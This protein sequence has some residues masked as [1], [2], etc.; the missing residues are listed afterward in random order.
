VKIREATKLISKVIVQVCTPTSNEGVSFHVPHYHQYVLSLEFSILPIL[1]DVRWNLRV[2]WIWISL[3]TKDIEHFLLFFSFLF[4]SFLFFSS[5]LFSS[6]SLFSFLFSLFSFLFSLFSFSSLSFLFS[7]FLSFLLSVCLSVCL[8]FCLSFFL[9]IV[10]GSVVG[11]WAIQPPVPGL[12]GSV[13]SGL[14]LLVWVSSWTSH[15]LATPTTCVSW[16]LL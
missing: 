1:T 3:V 7:F 5:L 6:L 12:P 11:L 10:F 13:R 8:S 9:R 15:R 16:N 14:P 4:F 2:V